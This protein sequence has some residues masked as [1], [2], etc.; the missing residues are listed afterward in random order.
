MMMSLWCPNCEKK[1]LNPYNK[2]G[3]RPEKVD[4]IHRLWCLYCNYT[5]KTT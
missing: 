1:G 5:I 3:I 2:K 4:N